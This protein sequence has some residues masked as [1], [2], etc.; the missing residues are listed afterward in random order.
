MYIFLEI[1][2]L[3]VLGF[4]FVFFV[5]QAYNIFFKG[6]APFVATKK[7]IIRKAIDEIELNEAK[8]VYELGCGRAGFL[9]SIRRR[10]PKTR[11]VGFEYS[12]LPVVLAKIQNWLLRG[13]IQIIKKDIFKVDLSEA[14]LIYCYLNPK[15]M[16]E[17][18]EKFKKE[19]KQD[20][21]IIS[22]Q[23]K[24]EGWEAKKVIENGDDK[25]YLYYNN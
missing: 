11:L 4:W 7:N 3:A 15:M 6:Y 8:T 1:L 14:D 24:I 22:F 18:K 9:H 21:K 20:A 5:I 23:F 19:M 25:I 16:Q 10:Y 17:L 12:L 13:N 2:F